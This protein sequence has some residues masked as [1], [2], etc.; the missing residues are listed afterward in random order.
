MGILLKLWEYCYNYGN[1]VKIMGIMFII[2]RVIIK[3]FLICLKERIRPK[4]ILG[5]ILKSLESGRH[6]MCY[7][8]LFLLIKYYKLVIETDDQD[9]Q[10]NFQI[11]CIVEI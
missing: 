3:S 2:M 1:N 10:F 8:N 4:I 9:Y 11:L 6:L 7:T 5:S